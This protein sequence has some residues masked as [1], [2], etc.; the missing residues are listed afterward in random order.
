MKD[1][2]RTKMDGLHGAAHTLV[3]GSTVYYRYRG[4]DGRIVIVDSASDVPPEARDRA[5]R[6]ELGRAS[7]GTTTALATRLDWPSFAGGFGLALVFAAIVLLGRRG[8]LRWLGFLAIFGL[9]TVGF[10]AYLGFLRR[11]TGQTTAIFASPSAVIDDARRAV[12]VMKERERERDRMIDQI[13]R[14]GK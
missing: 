2:E 6:I 9:L 12:E 11:S 5:E 13:Q 3:P 14:E 1:P 8:S 4:P 10:G 7:E